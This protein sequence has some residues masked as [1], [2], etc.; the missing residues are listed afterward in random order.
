MTIEVRDENRP[1]PEIER[2][3]LSGVDQLTQLQQSGMGLWLVALIVDHADWT[4]E[5]LVNE[6]QGKIIRIELPKT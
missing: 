3:I 4:V 2:N 5:Y 1:I 6:S